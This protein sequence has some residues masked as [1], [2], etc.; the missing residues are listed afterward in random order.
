[1]LGFFEP[2]ILLLKVSEVLA[3]SIFQCPLRQGNSINKKI[4]NVI[5]FKPKFKEQGW[6]QLGLGGIMKNELEEFIY[7]ND[8]QDKSS[9]LLP[10]G[11]FF[12]KN[13]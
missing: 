12:K 9:V 5:N 6:L 13:K 2:F 8:F 10:S 11:K 7:K 1:M 4:K 3:K